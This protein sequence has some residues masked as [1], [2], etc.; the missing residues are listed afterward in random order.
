VLK[1]GQGAAGDSHHYLGMSTG[2]DGGIWIIDGYGGSR[3]GWSYAFGKVLGTARPD[4]DLLRAQVSALDATHDRLQLIVDNLGD[5]NSPPSTV[6]LTFVHPGSRPS[7]SSPSTS[8]RSR[9][10]ATVSL[11]SA[12]RPPRSQ[13]AASPKTATR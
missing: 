7:R 10:A 13:A 11:R 6:K 2:S 3:G 12:S 9:T 8:P 1:A 4:L 5:G